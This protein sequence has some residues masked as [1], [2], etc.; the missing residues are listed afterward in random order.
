MRGGLHGGDEHLT[1][2]AALE[3]AILLRS[4][5]NDFISPM[6]G[7]MLRAFA[8]NSPHELAESSF[9]VLEGPILSPSSGRSTC[10]GVL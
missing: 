6:H 1:R 3:T 9:G 2:E 10:F 4:Y 5:N 7:D 8:S